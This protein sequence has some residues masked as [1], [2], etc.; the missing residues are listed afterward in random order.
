MNH[1]KSCVELPLLVESL[2]LIFYMYALH[3]IIGSSYDVELDE[4]KLERGG[5]HS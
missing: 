2:S 5:Q 3:S 4:A 1:P